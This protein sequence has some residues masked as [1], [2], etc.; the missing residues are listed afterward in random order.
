VRQRLFVS[1]GIARLR[2]G[3]GIPRRHRFR[4]CQDELRLVGEES[5]PVAGSGS[6]EA[7]GVRTYRTRE[8]GAWLTGRGDVG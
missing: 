3:H 2:F 1:P 5:V 6:R 4:G 7:R 8:R